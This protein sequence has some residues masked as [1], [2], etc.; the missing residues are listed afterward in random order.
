MQKRERVT[1]DETKGVS[2]ILTSLRPAVVKQSTP[3]TK[4]EEPTKAVERRRR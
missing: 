2:R 1:L 3:S 4:A